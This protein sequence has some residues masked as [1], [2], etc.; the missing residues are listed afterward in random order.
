MKHF[1]G[2][3]VLPVYDL[4]EQ[5]N[6]IQNEA[7]SLFATD[8]GNYVPKPDICYPDVPPVREPI[9]NGLFLGWL[10]FKFAYFVWTRV[11]RLSR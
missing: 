5:L 6:Q 10:F 1:L 11:F 8:I 3:D 4:Q 2:D 9:P 7:R